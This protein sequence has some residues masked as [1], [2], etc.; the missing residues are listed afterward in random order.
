M[1]AQQNNFL[2][3]SGAHGPD[4]C[5]VWRTE[6]RDILKDLICNGFVL[7]Y[8]LLSLPSSLQT[9]L[10]QMLLCLQFLTGVLTLA[11]CG[12]ELVM[13]NSGDISIYRYIVI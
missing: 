8:S 4:A 11:N 6:E 9:L 2:K 12:N 13:C 7:G 1:G 3:F 10:P 5:G